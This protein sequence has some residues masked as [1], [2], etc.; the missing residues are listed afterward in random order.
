MDL[1]YKFSLEGSP[2]LD[3]EHEGNVFYEWRI[4][5]LRLALG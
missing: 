3:L 5:G 4:L 1:Y 2:R